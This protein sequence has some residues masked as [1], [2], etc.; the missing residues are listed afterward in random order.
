MADIGR[1]ILTL[2]LEGLDPKRKLKSSE[3]FLGTGPWAEAVYRNHT[4]V[5]DFFRTVASRHR[6]P[7]LSITDKNFFN[8]FKLLQAMSLEN[9]RLVR[10]D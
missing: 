8:Y 3:T 7:A 4:D 10:L 6:D 1:N 9:N 5:G 2:A